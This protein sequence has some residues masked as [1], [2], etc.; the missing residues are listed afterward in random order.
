[1]YY[2]L[3]A[4]FALAIIALVIWLFSQPSHAQTIVP[5]KHSYLGH[6]EVVKVPSW[7]KEL[8]KIK[9][10]N[11]FRIED[12]F[13]PPNSTT[14]NL[15]I[16]SSISLADDIRLKASLGGRRAYGELAYYVRGNQ[17]WYA[18]QEHNDS[19]VGWRIRW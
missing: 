18:R 14:T 17:E 10:V 6:I 5:S 7:A 16:R 2:I 12:L 3:R 1:M 19:T 11:G 8:M 4:V 15:R 13:R 9:V